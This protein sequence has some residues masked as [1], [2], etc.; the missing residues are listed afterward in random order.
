MAELDGDK[1]PPGPEYKRVS[2]RDHRL[3]NLGVGLFSGAYFI[4]ALVPTMF[5]YEEAATGDPIRHCE[6]DFTGVGGSSCRQP[7]VDQ[8]AP[9]FIP[10]VGPWATMATT[11]DAN[12]LSLPGGLMLGLAGLAQASGVALTVVGLVTK[13]KVHRFV[14]GLEPRV[15]AGSVALAGSF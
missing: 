10:I 15:G 14:G 2:V 3:V 13:R 6:F 7:Y 1:T 9:L 11:S 5:L 4:G 12:N 8:Y